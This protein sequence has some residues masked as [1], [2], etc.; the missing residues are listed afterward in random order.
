IDQ[1]AHW[2]GAATQ[3]AAIPNDKPSA[4]YG[5]YVER[6]ITDQDRQYWAFKKPV[7]HS[8]PTVRDA[9]WTGNPIDAFVKASLDAKGMVPAPEA[10]RRTLI[11]RLYLDVIG[12][13]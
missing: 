1:G 10:D 6:V 2:G 5:D 13:L 3:A 9:R 7:R 12:L 11:R 8:P 4:G